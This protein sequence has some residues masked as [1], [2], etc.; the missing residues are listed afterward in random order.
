MFVKISNRYDR[1]KFSK[2]PFA[3]PLVPRSDEIASR[4]MER[5]LRASRGVRRLFN[6][7]R[8]AFTMIEVLL[9][10]SILASSV[11]LLSRL[12]V[13]SLFRVMRDR[14]EIEKIFLIKKDF[15]KFLY[16][17]DQKNWPLQTKPL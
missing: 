2:K 1:K 12:N 9:A 15:Y 4:G 11:F 13:R 14:D 17:T 8:P 6:T 5:V 3:R 10:L 7:S 16:K